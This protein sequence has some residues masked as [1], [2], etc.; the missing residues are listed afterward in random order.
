MEI[1]S[2]RHPLKFYLSLIFISAF[3]IGIGLIFIFSSIRD[4]N[5]KG[6][7]IFYFFLATAI[8]FNYKYITNSYKIILNKKGI[9][10]KN[11][12]YSWDDISEIKLTGKRGLIIN[13]Q[14]ECATLTFKNLKTIIIFDDIYSNSSDMKYFIQKIVIN[15]NDRLEPYKEIKN[16]IEYE[17]QLFITYKGNAVLSFRGILMWSLISFLIIMPFYLK[18]KIEFDVSILFLIGFSLIWFILNSYMM[19]YFEISKDY[20]IVK[21][22]YFF[23]IK[24]VY[25]ISSIYEIVYETQ[26]KQPNKLKIITKDFKS[27]VFPAGSLT[28]KTWLEMKSEL[29]SKNISVRNEC[30]Y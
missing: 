16:S 29:E 14:T 6:Y 21:N 17:N 4:N 2:K 27:K 12:F 11:E 3:L 18:R 15:K 7:F 26:S 9:H 30:I 13:A 1:V 8:Y 25:N 20:F 10:Y 22:H 28:Y 5:V 24:K 19:F 23:W